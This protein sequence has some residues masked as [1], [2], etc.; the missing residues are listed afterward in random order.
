MTLPD[1]STA[2][3]WAD[4]V[5]F[6]RIFSRQEAHQPLDRLGRTITESS[7]EIAIHLKNSRCSMC[8]LAAGR[9]M[10]MYVTIKLPIQVGHHQLLDKIGD[11]TATWPMHPKFAANA[12]ASFA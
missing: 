10:S 8:P 11:V 9:P 4:F 1:W 7:A 12:Q 3:A 5:A 2:A 6:W